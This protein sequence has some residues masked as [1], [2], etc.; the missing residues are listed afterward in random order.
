MKQK[1]I[2][3]GWKLWN[4][5]RNLPDGHVPG[6]VSGI[7]SKEHQDVFAFSDERKDR[8]AAFSDEKKIKS[9]IFGRKKNKEFF[10][11]G[12]EIYQQNTYTFS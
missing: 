3:I 2:V 6:I 4:L 10:G 5:K 1:G 7:L 12:S 11:S 9:C 8:R